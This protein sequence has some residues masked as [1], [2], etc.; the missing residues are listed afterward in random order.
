MTVTPTI[1]PNPALR[2]DGTL[3][4]LPSLDDGHRALLLTAADIRWDQVG[5]GWLLMMSG[6]WP[7]PH[8]LVLL[9]PDDRAYGLGGWNAEWLLLDWDGRRILY[10]DETSLVILDPVNGAVDAGFAAS[11][12]EDLTWFDAGLAPNAEAVVVGAIGLIGED[13]FSIDIRTQD[14][15]VTSVLVDRSIEDWGLWPSWKRHP[16][17]DLLAVTNDDLLTLWDGAGGQV[18][19][20][21][22][23]GEGCLVSRWWTDGSVLVS[24]V[25][26]DYAMSGT[27]ACWPGSGTRLW[28]V[29]I[30][31]A[32]PEAL[33]PPVGPGGEDCEGYQPGYLDALQIGTVLL[34]E[35]GGCCECGGDLVVV[36]PEGTVI[37]PTD[38][39]AL[40]TLECAP[41]LVTTRSG[42][43]LVAAA[44]VTGDARDPALFEMTPTLDV[45]RML[46]GLAIGRVLA[47]PEFAA[48]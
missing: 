7:N 2:E 20:L 6:Q 11:D 26:P 33:T 15:S 27:A 44:D 31:G 39:T 10:Q 48:P 36:E 13:R 5:P 3:L 23:P 30:D 43:F 9:A 21:H 35:T 42:A 19:L 41:G 17:D 14:G 16:A 47:F 40:M 38:N 37:G 32:A 46:P 28:L 12:G 8:E 24:C 22:L 45:R 29:P 18:G 25:D 1:A 4:A 34:A